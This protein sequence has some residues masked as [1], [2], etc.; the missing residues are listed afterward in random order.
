MS[1]KELQDAFGTNLVNNPF[2]IEHV[3]KINLFMHEDIFNKGTFEFTGYV[4][5]CNG[6]TSGEQKFVGK[7]FPDLFNQIVDFCNSLK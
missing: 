6:N 3:K 4:A 5:F 7:N 2:S 1:P